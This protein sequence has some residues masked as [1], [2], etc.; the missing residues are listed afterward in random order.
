MQEI[1]VEES[2]SRVGDIKDRLGSLGVEMVGSSRA[3]EQALQLVEAVAPNDSGVLLQGETGTGKELFARAIHMLSSRQHGPFVTLNCAAVPAGLVESELFG[4]ERGAFTGAV[5][6]LVGRFQLADK[7][8]LFLDEIGELPLEIQPKLLRALQEHEFA[9]LGS[10][11]TVRADVRIIA[12]TNQN[13]EEMVR[14]RK[15]R[16]DLYFRLNVFPIVLPPL[17]ARAEDIP[18]LVQYFVRKLSRQLKKPIEHVPVEV[19]DI[20]SA[21]EWSGNIRELE[22]FIHRSVILSKGPVLRP[23]LAELRAIT[24]GSPQG[25]TP[26][27]AEVEREHIVQ[28]LRET[29]GLVGGRDGAAARLGIPRTTL[30]YRMRKLGIPVDKF[31]RSHRS[32]AK[33]RLFVPPEM[34]G[35][36]ECQ[37]VA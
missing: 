35:E 7:G 32:G 17:R 27:L 16:P 33:N 25:L 10:G 2:F 21:H 18:E 23:P 9:R 28:V 31:S 1:S 26:T 11:R 4:H 15:F 6:P 24:K 13:L 22:N 20:L 34:G 19:L 12:A 3:F 14:E 30:L 29:N 8:T 5:S 37:V 36:Q